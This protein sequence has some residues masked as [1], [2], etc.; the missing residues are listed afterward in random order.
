MITENNPTLLTMLSN[1]PAPGPIPQYI[2]TQQLHRGVT[3]NATT[4]NS[5][6]CTFAVQAGLLIC[7]AV[8]HGDR[9]RRIYRRAV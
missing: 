3:H 4:Y 2:T 1:C 5:S 7:E 9:R 6:V 8:V